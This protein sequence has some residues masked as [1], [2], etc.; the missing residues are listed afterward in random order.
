MN[1]KVAGLTLLVI[2]AILGGYLAV[3][4]SGSQR[5]VTTMLRITVTPKE[6]LEFVAAKA[7]SPLFKYLVG[8]KTGVKPGLAQRLEIKAVA[9]SSVL[10]A[11]M[12]RMTKAEDQRY[13]AA[14]VEVLQDMCGKQA[15][16]TLAEQVVR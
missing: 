6:E 2:G 11:K 5:S 10:E 4:K 12:V 15:Q 1:W 13:A 14:F 8:K 9:N 16:L 7:K 3:K